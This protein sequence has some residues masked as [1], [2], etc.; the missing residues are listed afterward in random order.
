MKFDQG[1][2]AHSEPGQVIGVP[3]YELD[4]KVTHQAGSH[5]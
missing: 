5:P 1:K 4:G 3:S 2:A